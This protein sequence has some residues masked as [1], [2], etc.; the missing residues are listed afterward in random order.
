MK[1]Y[2][3]N[4][5]YIKSRMI[6]KA[7]EDAYKTY[8][9]VHKY[10]FT[11]IHLAVPSKFIDVNVHPTKMEVRFNNGEDKFT[12]LFMNLSKGPEQRELIPK[13]DI[14]KDTEE[15]PAARAE[16]LMCPNHLEVSRLAALG[17]NRF[18]KEGAAN[19]QKP[20]KTKK[21][22]IAQRRFLLSL[23]IKNEGAGKS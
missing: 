7:I 14:A 18:I 8:V 22:V 17:K 19:Y 10:P 23:P 5:R 20:E 1:N 16:I 3:I 9:M 6:T 12:V 2:Y 4:G 21:L 11:V 13:A 15:T